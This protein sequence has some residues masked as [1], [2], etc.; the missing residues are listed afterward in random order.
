M[1]RT[2]QELRSNAEANVIGWKRLKRIARKD[3]CPVGDLAEFVYSDSEARVV[4]CVEEQLSV[5]LRHIS[6]SFYD[7]DF[8]PTRA[9]PYMEQLGFEIKNTQCYS[10][11]EDTPFGKA[12]NCVQQIS[13][14]NQKIN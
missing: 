7:G 11:I 1:N 3:E 2:L 4:Y 5:I 9:L 12:V 14:Q 6:V 10:W 13:S 8:K